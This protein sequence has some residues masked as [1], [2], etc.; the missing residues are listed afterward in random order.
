MATNGVRFSKRQAGMD[1]TPIVKTKRKRS[2]KRFQNKDDALNNDHIDDHELVDGDNSIDQDDYVEASQRNEENGEDKADDV[3]DVEPNQPI[4]EGILP[5]SSE[6]SETSKRK[7]RGPTKMRKVTKHHDDKVDV[8]FTP[9]G[10]N[11]GT[12]SVTLSSFLSPLVRE[13]VPVLLEDWR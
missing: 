11:V 13:H 12:G 2:K 9:V 5:P 1:V 4:E 3:E 10:E 8:E 7:T 6:H